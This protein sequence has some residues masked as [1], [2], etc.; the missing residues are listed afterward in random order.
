[1]LHREQHPLKIVHVIQTLSPKFGGP[2]T[3]LQSMAK[4]QSRAGHEV[5]ILTTNLDYPKGILTSKSNGFVNGSLAEIKYFPA[6][7]PFLF[8]SKDLARS[9]QLKIPR[10]DVIHVW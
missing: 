8:L 10:I 6:E 9:L 5:T 2:A 3:V 4:E 7:I 1:M